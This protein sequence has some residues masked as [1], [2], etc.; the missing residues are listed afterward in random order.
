MPEQKSGG[1]GDDQQCNVSARD[2]QQ[3]ERRDQEQRDERRQDV[4]QPD[5]IL[6]PQRLG[7]IGVPWHVGGHARDAA[8]EHR[9]AHRRHKYEMHGQDLGGARQQRLRLLL[10]LGLEFDHA[11]SN[12]EPRE[13]HEQRHRGFGVADEH[14]PG[15]GKITREMGDHHL[16]DGEAAQKINRREARRGRTHEN[17][18]RKR[19]NFAT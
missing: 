1:A 11:P 17:I 10:R 3:H 9:H 15:R 16:G 19:G 2:G 12:H 5:L 6:E 13:H 4:K 18:P 7:E 14:W 8:G